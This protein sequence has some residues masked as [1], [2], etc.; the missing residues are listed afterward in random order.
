MG[1]ITLLI[2]DEVGGLQVLRDGQ[3][4]TVEPLPDAIV[5]NLGDQTQVICMDI[6][7]LRLLL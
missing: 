7:H 1:A 4:I 5:V 6:I 3:W 2:Q